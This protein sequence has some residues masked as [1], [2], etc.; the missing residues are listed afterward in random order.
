VVM[1]G[2]QA[3]STDGPKGGSSCALK[4]LQWSPQ[5]QLMNVVWCSVV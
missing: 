5:P 1:H 2:W 4:W 3:E